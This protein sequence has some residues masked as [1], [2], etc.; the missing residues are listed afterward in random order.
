MSWAFGWVTNAPQNNNKPITFYL[1]DIKYNKERLDEPRF[2]VSY[3][4][5]P[6]D[7]PVLKDTAFTYDNALVLLAFLAN[8]TDEDIESAKLIG[9]ALVYA[10]DN[11]RYFTDGRLR[12]AYQAGDLRLPPGWK[13]H[14]KADTVRMPGWW[15]TKNNIWYEDKTFVGT[16]SGNVAWSI[17]ALLSLY[18]ETHKDRYLNASIRLGEW[19]ENECR[20]ER[21][22]GGFTGGYEGWEKTANNPEGQTK[23]LWKSTEHNIDVYVAFSRLYELTGN[24]VWEERAKH[25]K[26]LVEAMWDEREGHLWTGTLEDGITI[27]KANIPA[28]I[29]AW[30]IMAMDEIDKYERG[31]DWVENNCY[32]E[33]DGFKGFDFNNDTDGIWFEGSVH[34]AIAY[35]IVREE[36]KA[37]LYL[38]ELRRAQKEA[39]N[40]NGKG[41]VA[42]SHD[43]VSTGFDWIYDARLH[44]GATAWFIFGE[45]GNN[46]YWSS[47]TTSS[48]EIFT[49]TGWNLI[50]LPLMP[51]DTSTDSV[52]SPIS[53]NYSIIWEY[54]ASDTADHWKKY[55]PGAPFGN[56]LTNMEPGKGYWIMM[57]SDDILEI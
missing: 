7:E 41:L 37:N 28:D 31:I 42:A 18:E 12:N 3:E 34:M 40:T 10:I 2:L 57:T 56:D 47:D 24:V 51:E 43:R 50:S 44:T 4:L 38:D 55:D 54:N 32:V 23:I 17:I 6:D 14:G 11:D 36:I 52:L 1:D 8:N 29:H 20:D 45:A 15:D 33:A 26:Y 39:N 22:A 5:L 30:S 25:A 19:I 16:H 27:N 9:D 46:P 35:Q 49:Y 48:L 21:G 53:G 13:P